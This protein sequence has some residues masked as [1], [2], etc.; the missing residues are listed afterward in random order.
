[1]PQITAFFDRYRNIVDR[2]E[3]EHPL[4]KRAGLLEVEGR[5]ADM[6]KSSVFHLNCSCSG[7]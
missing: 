7:F 4:V 2:L 1:M 3:T 5:E 6:R